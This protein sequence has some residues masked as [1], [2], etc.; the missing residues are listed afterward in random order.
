M[1][2]SI[3][4][5]GTRKDAEDHAGKEGSKKGQEVC[6]PT[7]LGTVDVVDNSGEKPAGKY[8]EDFEGK[9]GI[10]IFY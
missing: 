10:V 6:G 9:W 7:Q 8:F 3:Q 2:I 5:F 1:N 4:V